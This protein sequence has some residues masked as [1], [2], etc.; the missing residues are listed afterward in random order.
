MNIKP[1]QIPAEAV[2]IA[3][4]TFDYFNLATPDEVVFRAVLAAA[5]PV[6]LG[7]PVGGWQPIEMA[8]TDGKEFIAVWGHQGNVMQIVRWS[9]TCGHFETK[10]SPVY[11]FRSNA[12][13]WHALPKP[14]SAKREPPHT[15]HAREIPNE[16]IT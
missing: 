4:D 6:L 2:E 16:R 7:E 3:A 13:A 10:G 15:I 9:K 11:G 5:L 12:T 1:E 14:P 8:P